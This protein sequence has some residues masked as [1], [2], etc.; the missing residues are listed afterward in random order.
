MRRGLRRRYPHITVI[1]PQPRLAE[2]DFYV[3][4]VHLNARG[5]VILSELLAEELAVLSGGR[6]GAGEGRNR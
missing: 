2:K 5:A 6:T 3:D 4:R 1:E